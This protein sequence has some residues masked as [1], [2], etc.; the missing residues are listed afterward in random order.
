VTA[1]PLPAGPRHAL[2]TRRALSAAFGVCLLPLQVLA[3]AA[4]AELAAD[5]QDPRLQGSGRLRY[6]G[7]HI[8]DARLWVGEG[9]VPAQWEQHRLA[10]ELQ[11]ARSLR[12]D[13][14]AERSLEEMRGIAAIDDA[15]AQAWLARMREAFPDVGDGDRL[16]GL[17]LP[18]AGARFFHNGRPRSQWQDGERQDAELARRFFGIWLSPRTSQPAL[19]SALLGAGA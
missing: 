8:Y 5:L 6:F 10:L 14:I 17:Y 1:S 2:L 18:G 16:T 12:G 7:L 15:R 11:Y 9:F 13:L 4:P 19:R 3:A